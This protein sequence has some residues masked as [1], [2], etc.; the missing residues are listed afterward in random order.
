MTVSDTRASATPGVPLGVRMRG[1]AYDD[2]PATCSVKDST[3]GK[4]LLLQL[5]LLLI[6]HDTML[7]S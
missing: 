7:W 3:H 2:L 6:W 5:C 1:V 4:G